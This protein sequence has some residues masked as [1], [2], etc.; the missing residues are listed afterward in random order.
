MNATDHRGLARLSHWVDQLNEGVGR[1]VSWLTL[2]MVLVT[3]TVVVLRYLFNMGWIAMQ[4][5]VIYMHA[6]V[7]MLGAAYTLK[8]AGHVRVD[9]IYRSR[10]KRTQAWI[11][12]WGSLLLLLPV[13]LFIAWISWEYIAA[14]WSVKETSQE[15]GGIPA[16]FLLK[17]IIP[18]MAS[19]MVL[20][21]LS[22][23][24]TNLLYL[25]SGEPETLDQKGT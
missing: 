23:F 5:S 16:V 13:C 1:A 25:L 17:T 11:D 18:V 12:L 8:N 15:A 21:G 3:F 24:L 4:E 14:S 2:G 10:S 7:F 19:L 6:A 22:Q 9:L 20:Q